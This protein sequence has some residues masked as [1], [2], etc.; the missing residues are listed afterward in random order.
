[1]PKCYI[2]EK[3]ISCRCASQ[4]HMKLKYRDCFCKNIYNETFPQAHLDFD[5]RECHIC[6]GPCVE[7]FLK[8]KLE[9]LSSLYIN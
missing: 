8:K 4:K 7:I 9:K 5:N 1:M 2:C 3:K 6:S